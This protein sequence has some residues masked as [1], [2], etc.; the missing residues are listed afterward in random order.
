MIRARQADERSLRLPPR[1]WI[2]FCKRL[3]RLAKFGFER[4]RDLGQGD[5]EIARH[6]GAGVG[7]GGF[8]RGVRARRF[9]VARYAPL[10]EQPQRAE[11]RGA[12]AMGEIVGER[13]EAI[14]LEV[15]EQHLLFVEEMRERLALAAGGTGHEVLR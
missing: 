7:E 13:G 12:A 4:L 10:L 6:Q 5:E 1:A 11:E 14:V 15:L 2:D 3:R 9:D 8:E